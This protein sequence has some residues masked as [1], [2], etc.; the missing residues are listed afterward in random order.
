MSIRAAN[1][2]NEASTSANLLDAALS[3][4]RTQLIGQ[5]AD[6]TSVDGR[7]VG[8]LGFSGALLAADLAAKGALGGFWWMPLPVLGVAALFVVLDRRS[9]LA[10]I[11]GEVRTWPDRRYFLSGIQN[12]AAIGTPRAAVVR[13]HQSL[14]PTMPLAC[15]R[16]SAP[17]GSPW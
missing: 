16:R 4:A 11:S 6:E 17:Y 14:S 9:A 10:S 13:S 15:R 2:H 8:T 1:A 5:L 12:R 3:L 7:M